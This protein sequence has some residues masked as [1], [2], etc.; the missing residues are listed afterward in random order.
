MICSGLVQRRA[1][2]RFASEESKHAMDL[3]FLLLIALLAS[4]TWG[5]VQLCEKV[6][7]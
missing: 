1:T 3:A 6:S 2:L 7:T 5:F 4:L